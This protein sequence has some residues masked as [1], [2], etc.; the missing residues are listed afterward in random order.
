MRKLKRETK[1]NG[2]AE[3]PEFVKIWN[4]KHKEKMNLMND[5]IAVAQGDGE[6]WVAEWKVWDI[7]VKHYIQKSEKYYA[8]DDLENPY[9]VK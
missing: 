4:S 7:E 1:T 2:V 8:Y 5:E 3:F 6:I 9:I